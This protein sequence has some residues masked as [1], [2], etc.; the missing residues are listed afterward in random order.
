MTARYTC[1]T[2]GKVHNDLP[3]SFAAEFPDMYANMKRE[4]RDVRTVIG[5]DQCIIDQ[6]WFFIRGCIEIPI[7]GESEPF[8][9][10][11]W[12]SIKQEVFMRSRTHGNFK[13]ESER[14]SHTK[15]DWQTL[16]PSI[17]KRST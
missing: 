17:L 5:S 16:S 1:T 6:K 7:I 10:G 12:A 15:G 9:W 8:L 4:E 14:A 11:V 13:V 3:R 2:C